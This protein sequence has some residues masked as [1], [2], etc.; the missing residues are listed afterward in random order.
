MTDE[1]Q[2]D[3]PTEIFLLGVPEGAKSLLVNIEAFLLI[4]NHIHVLM[5]I[6]TWP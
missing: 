4:N 1:G 2:E 6:H 3:L 5:L